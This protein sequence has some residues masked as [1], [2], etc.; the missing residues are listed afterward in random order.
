MNTLRQVLPND[1]IFLDG[2]SVVNLC[3]SILEIFSEAFF[4]LRNQIESDSNTS[5][6]ANLDAQYMVEAPDPNSRI[7]KFS[8]FC[9]STQCVNA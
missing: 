5:I 7:L 9:F 4:T 1:S 8:K 2:L 3:T 6:N